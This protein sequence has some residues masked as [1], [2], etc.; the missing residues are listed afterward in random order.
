MSD[1][2]RLHSF[3]MLRLSLSEDPFAQD[4]QQVRP[5]LDVDFNIMRNN[6]DPDRF[7][8]ILTLSGGSGTE[9]AAARGLCYEVTGG[10]EFEL[11]SIVEPEKRG[12]I[13]A[14]NG[15]AILYGLIR[16]QVAMA[17]GSF[18]SGSLLLPT[19]DWKQKV[20]EIIERKSKQKRSTTAGKD[21]PKEPPLDTSGK[22]KPKR[23]RDLTLRSES[24]KRKVK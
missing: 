12:M 13:I 17:T 7:L 20:H 1:I 4:A 23:R 6:T 21:K 10:A 22:N 24:G 11:P 19:I 9:T 16:G 2:L 8:M 5:K 14:I 15:G 3:K 18:P